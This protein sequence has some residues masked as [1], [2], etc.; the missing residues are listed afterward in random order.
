MFYS[1]TKTY[2]H[3]KRLLLALL[4]LPLF[5]SCEED[6]EITNFGPDN[7]PQGR[8]RSSYNANLSIDSKCPPVF[9]DYRLIGGVLPPGISMD[10]NGGFSG[11]PT[12]IGI[13]NFTVDTEVCF[14]QDFYGFYDCLGTTKGFT[15][16]VTP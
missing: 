8:L 6:C 3:F 15:I 13:F 10:V 4:S 1:K 11:S 16:I 9:A 7:L 2:P 14:S 5:I 12:Q